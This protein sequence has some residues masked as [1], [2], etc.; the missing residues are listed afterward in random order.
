MPYR[1]EVDGLRAVAVVPVIL[2][3]AGFGY[4]SGGFIGVDIFFVISGFLIT[5]ILADEMASGRYS[6][7]RFYE[8]RA[9]RVL[10]AL[11]FV[12]IVSYLF[13]WRWMQPGAFLDYSRSIG[14]ATFFVSNIHFWQSTDYFAVADAQLPLLHTWS[15]AVEEQFYLVFPLVLWAA[16]RL[17]PGHVMPILAVAAL[18]SLGLSEWGWRN[19]QEANFVLAPTR[20]WELL[21]GACAA[22][23]C[24][25]QTGQPPYSQI[26]SAIG[27]AMMLAPFFIYDETVPFPS[28]YALLPVV[29]ATLMLVFGRQGTLAASVLSL[30]IFVGISTISYSAHLWHQPLFALAR[31]RLLEPPSM[32]VMA[33][34]SLGSLALAMMSWRF[35]EQPLRRKAGPTALSTPRFVGLMVAVALCLGGASLCGDSH[36]ADIAAAMRLNGQ[37]VLQVTGAGCPID[38]LAMPRKCLRLAEFFKSKLAGNG[39]TEIWL[40]NRFYPPE[41]TGPA[42]QD[43]LS[44]WETKGI[45]LSLFSPIPE[46]PDMRDRLIKSVWLGSKDPLPVTRP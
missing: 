42:M 44:F 1:R 24:Q 10:P 40:A 28:V 4:P 33:G 46:F 20:A 43:V 45:K 25:R 14:A 35:V 17:A 37:S 5:S 27:L 2:W 22:L 30:P 13:A 16:W 38:P 15:L 8:C 41:L 7:L 26:H 36:A 34:L 19:A 3:H 23:Y 21:A 31:I 29:G 6:I 11:F 39:I 9:R 32:M 18:A 12:I